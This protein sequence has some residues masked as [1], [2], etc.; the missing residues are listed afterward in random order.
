[1]LACRIGSWC[2]MGLPTFM[3]L[4]AFQNM[5]S[6]RKAETW[7]KNRRQLVRLWRF[8]PKLG[9]EEG[10]LCSSALTLTSRLIDGLS[11]L[12]SRFWSWRPVLWMNETVFLLLEVVPPAVS[13]RSP[14]ILPPRRP[15][16]RWARRTTSRLRSSCRRD[17][18][19]CATGGLWGSSC[20]K[21]S[22]VRRIPVGPMAPFYGRIVLLK[23]NCPV[24]VQATHHS[25]RRRHRRPT[26]R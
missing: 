24:R 19:S 23:R 6:K 4:T 16:P 26:G 10:K 21:C 18:T 15:I 11:G 5:N 9:Q 1:M 8:R 3:H 2:V 20:T 17:T 13:R 7:K 12:F 25:A 14:R 22:S